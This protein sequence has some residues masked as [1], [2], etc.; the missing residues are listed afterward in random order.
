MYVLEHRQPLCNVGS[1]NLS[2]LC[3]GA[4]KYPT[5][6]AGGPKT[7]A[8]T[9]H[10]ECWFCAGC[11]TG[12]TVSSAMEIRDQNLS[13]FYMNR[14]FGLAPFQLIRNKK[15]GLVGFRTGKIWYG[16]SAA[17][18]TISGVWLLRFIQF[19]PLTAL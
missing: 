16:Y 11:G 18:I 15:G 7:A 19:P 5:P 1:A 12:E 17:L 14:I 6:I 9:G 8:E 3:P 4:Y 2:P 10:R 13:V